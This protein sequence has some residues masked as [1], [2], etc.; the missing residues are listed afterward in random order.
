MKAKE[1]ENAG[2]EAMSKEN[3][4]PRGGGRKE[5]DH[6]ARAGSGQCLELHLRSHSLHECHSLSYLKKKNWLY[7]TTESRA[8]IVTPVREHRG[9]QS[10]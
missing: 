6:L 3:R 10:C 1:S 9:F 5:Q 8:T 2:N 4:E 7:W